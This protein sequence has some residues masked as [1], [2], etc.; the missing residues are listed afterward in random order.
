MLT[1]APLYGAQDPVKAK[2]RER[3]VEARR[4]VHKETSAQVDKRNDF[5]TAVS[6]SSC[7]WWWVDH[8]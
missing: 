2:L 7:V 6:L 1:S 8:V 3:V 5:E 4:A